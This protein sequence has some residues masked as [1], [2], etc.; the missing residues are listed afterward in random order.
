MFSIALRF[1]IRRN[2]IFEFCFPEPVVSIYE[3]SKYSFQSFYFATK[4]SAPASEYRDVV[5]DVS[6][7]SF[8]D[9]RIVLV[10]YVADMPSGINNI[11][12]P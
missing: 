8:N 12:I 9:K 1:M 3:Y 2:S 6:I 11:H 7:D 4:T 10:A 5:A